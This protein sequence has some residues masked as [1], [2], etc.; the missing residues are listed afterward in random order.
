MNSGRMDRF[1]LV[2]NG[3]VGNDFL[4]MT[5][6]L[7]LRYPELLELRR[8]LCPGGSHV[9][10]ARRAEFSKSPVHHRVAV[11]RCDQQPEFPHLGV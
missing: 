11:R 2:A 6:F 5:Q 10:V 3:N 7:E 9:F 8:A 1:D 4:S